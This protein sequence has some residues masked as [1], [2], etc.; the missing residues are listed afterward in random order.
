MMTK[1][2]REPSDKRKD[3]ALDKASAV[4]R[5][6]TE[7]GVAVLA[8]G[9]SGA[10]P[11]SS[12]GSANTRP[13][14]PL[15]CGSAASG[16]LRLLPSDVSADT[17]QPWSSAVYQVQM[18]HMAVSQ[19]KP[20]RPG[21]VPNMPQQRSDQ[22]HPPGTPTMMHPATAAGPPIVAPNP[23]YSAQYFTCSPQQFTSQ[24]LV[25]QMPHYQS[26]VQITVSA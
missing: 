7:E 18:P 9:N 1:P 8:A 6:D 13:A 16:G 12:A 21:K 20:Y 2:V 14:Q 11:A 3:L 10:V 26:Q 5:D 22:H 24:A 23:V 17:S 15:H 25:Q 19:S 4:G